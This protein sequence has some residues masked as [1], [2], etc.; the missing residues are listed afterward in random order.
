LIPAVLLLLYDFLSLKNDVNAPSKINKQK[1]VKK[2]FLEQDPDLLVRGMDPRIWIRN[3]MSQV[4]N[5]SYRS[6]KSKVMG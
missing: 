2:S 5:T 4:R 1:N 3:K 6:L